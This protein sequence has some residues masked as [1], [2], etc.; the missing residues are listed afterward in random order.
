[1]LTPP[2][3]TRNHPFCNE[4]RALTAVLPIVSNLFATFTRFGWGFKCCVRPQRLNMWIF[5]T[6]YYGICHCG[7]FFFFRKQTE[8]NILSEFSVW[9][10]SQR[11]SVVFHCLQ[12]FMCCLNNEL[13][14]GCFTKHWDPPVGI[15]LSKLFPKANTHPRTHCRLRPPYI[16]RFIATAGPPIKLFLWP[17][18]AINNLN[19]PAVSWTPYSRLTNMSWI[20]S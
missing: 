4:R 3:K 11:F 17:S 2:R 20:V 15:R 1:M 6:N 19:L 7:A 9:Y 12:L 16:I 13:C 10:K 18:S 5:L 8:Q 14:I